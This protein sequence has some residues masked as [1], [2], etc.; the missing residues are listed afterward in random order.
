LFH[1][2]RAFIAL[3][4][5]GVTF[6]AANHAHTPEELDQLSSIAK[7]YEK[8][9]PDAFGSILTNDSTTCVAFSDAV[10]N[11]ISKVDSMPLGVSTI[12]HEVCHYSDQMLEC[13]SETATGNAETQIGI[14]SHL[15]KELNSVL[16]VTA[17]QDDI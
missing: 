9:T 6:F 2:K 7:D 16:T 4:S 13:L 15:F 11:R 1:W 17:M 3:G 10:L 14:A 5:K 12:F 8:E